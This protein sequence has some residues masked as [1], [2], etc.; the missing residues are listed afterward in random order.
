MIKYIVNKESF[1]K[2]YLKD[3]V[4]CFFQFPR[5][6]GSTQ[7]GVVIVCAVI[8]GFG[9][10]YFICFKYKVESGVVCSVLG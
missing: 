2:S 9:V 3:R 7:Y 6:A 10:F 1:L 4:I 8:G 5:D